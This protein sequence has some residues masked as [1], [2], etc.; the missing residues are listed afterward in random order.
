MTQTKETTQAGSLE[1]TIRVFTAHYHNAAVGLTY[2]GHGA[3][4]MEYRIDWKPELE[5]VAGSGRIA[6]SVIY[7][8]LDASC[9][10]LPYVVTGGMI[11]AP[12][13]ELRVDHLRPPTPRKGLVFRGM[14][15]K[16]T[17]DM[18]YTRAI[19][20]EGDPEDPVAIANGTFMP[21]KGF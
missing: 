12:T 8:A 9:A 6:P 15:I 17:P 4:W 7:S 20:H 14:S 5:G 10:L 16:L 11:V 1:D 2:V 3:D 18:S 13:L 19:A 21:I